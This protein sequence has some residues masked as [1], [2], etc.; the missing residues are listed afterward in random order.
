MFIGKRP[1]RSLGTK[2]EFFCPQCYQ[3]RPFQ[4]Q[5]VHQYV[6]FLMV[7]I[8]PVGA[9]ERSVVCSACGAV[10]SDA[11]LDYNPASAEQQFIAEV[12]RIN[13]LIAMAEDRIEPAEIAALGRLYRELAGRELSREE[14]EEEV[15]QAAEEGLDAAAMVRQ[16][17]RTLGAEGARIVA[18]QAYLVAAASGTIS[19][20]RQ[21]QLDQFP[22]GLGIS[23]AGMQELIDAVAAEVPRPPDQEREP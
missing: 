14:I 19:E 2:G 3:A 9:A 16:I 17:G 18:Q 6:T 13:V 11:I 23:A 5:L 4:F 22:A 1:I 10:F 21:A 7:P 8:Y 12:F 20:K 15:R